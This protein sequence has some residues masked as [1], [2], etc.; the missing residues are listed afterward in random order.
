MEDDAGINPLKWKNNFQ[1]KV[2]IS[3]IFEMIQVSKS[4]NDESKQ[5]SFVTFKGR[6]LSGLSS[7]TSYPE[8]KKII[9]SLCVKTLLF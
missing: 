1:E 4:W 9:V 8:I 2:Q 5:K 7:Q 3:E 6:N